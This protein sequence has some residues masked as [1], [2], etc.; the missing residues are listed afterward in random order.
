MVEM[1]PSVGKG[2]RIGVKIVTRVGN[3]PLIVAIRDE[4]WEKNR[5]MVGEDPIRRGKMNV[6]V[7]AVWENHTMPRRAAKHRRPGS[8][9]VGLL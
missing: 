9:A 8:R 1:A 2:S 7:V 6:Q 4:K 5:A 3:V